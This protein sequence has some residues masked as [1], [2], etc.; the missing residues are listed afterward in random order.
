MKGCEVRRK[1]R[2]TAGGTMEK[3]VLLENKSRR[4]PEAALSRHVNEDGGRGRS[5]AAL[6]L[7]CS[8]SV[9]NIR[10]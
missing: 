7:V 2:F 6:M 3:Y 5:I 10:F 9:C 4:S 8:V 1:Q